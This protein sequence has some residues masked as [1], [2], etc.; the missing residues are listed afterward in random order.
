MQHNLRCLAIS[1]VSLFP[2][3]HGGAKNLLSI[4]QSLRN[5]GAECH[6][7]VK[8]RPHDLPEAERFAGQ[9][10]ANLL[11]HHEGISYEGIST[12][13]RNFV[14]AVEEKIESFHPDYFFLADDGLDNSEDL[15]RIGAQSGRL[16]FLA[17]TIHCLPFG[18]YSMLRSSGI[19]ESL[20]KAKNIIAPSQFVQTYIRDHAGLESQVYYPHV[21]GNGLFPKLGNFDNPYITMIN[22]CTW[23][24]SS[25]FLDIVKAR[26]HVKFAAVP[27]WG[28]QETLLKELSTLPNLTLLP[29]TKNIDEIFEKTRLLLTPSLCQEAFGLVSTEALLRGVPVVASDLAGLRE[30]TLGICPLIPVKALSFD[31]PA[32]EGVFPP[33]GWQPTENAIAPWLEAIDQ[34]LQDRTHYEEASKKAQAVAASFVERISQTSFYSVIT[35][36]K[37]DPLTALRGAGS[38]GR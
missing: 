5:S 4:L 17:Q 22:P 3:E 1:R 35:T 19:L 13:E 2:P 18:P 24:G 33:F 31:T 9:R 37:T 32:P 30:S 6:V 7:L 21:F 10:E 16:V 38:R 27:T 36:P 25:I 8:L 11:T 23:K 34:I 15:F 29:E 12:E 14:K 28:A 20:R 26:P